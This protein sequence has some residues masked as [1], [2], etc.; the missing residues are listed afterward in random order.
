M[1]ETTT[2]WKTRLLNL[3]PF[4]GCHLVICEYH[5][6]VSQLGH[7]LALGILATEE[8]NTV[9]DGIT[10]PADMTVFIPRVNWFLVGDNRCTLRLEKQILIRY[11]RVEIVPVVELQV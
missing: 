10:Q 6:K 7:Q 2:G 4:Y 11:F 8:V 5:L 3:N 1:S 9:K